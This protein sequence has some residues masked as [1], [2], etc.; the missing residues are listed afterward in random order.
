MEF[1]KEP[2]TLSTFPSWHLT[3]WSNQ[4]DI[5]GPWDVS[6]VNK[7]RE[8]FLPKNMKGRCVLGLVFL[9]I[10]V[11]AL[12]PV[13]FLSKVDFRGKFWPI[14]FLT[15]EGPRT[16]AKRPIFGRKPNLCGGL[17]LFWYPWLPS[18]H[19]GRI[20]VP[21]KQW[22]RCRCGSIYMAESD[23]DSTPAHE[24]VGNFCE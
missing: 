5:I 8:L 9:P 17:V 16:R 15:K 18:G 21:G 23:R 7:K 1:F 12:P 19:N 4:W 3:V 6:Y 11:C 20:F 24:R 14:S 22:G 13:V 10:L 2:S